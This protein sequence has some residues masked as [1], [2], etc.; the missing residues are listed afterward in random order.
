MFLTIENKHKFQIAA[1]I[2]S[3]GN[4]SEDWVQVDPAEVEK[5]VLNEGQYQLQLGLNIE[6]LSI[7]TVYNVMPG[8]KYYI[9]TDAF[10]KYEDSNDMVEPS[11]FGWVSKFST[12]DNS[13]TANF[14]S[15]IASNKV[16]VTNESHK[17]LYARLS[18]EDENF[19]DIAPGAKH[20]W[21]RQ[22]NGSYHFE[23][24]LRPKADR[25]PNFIILSGESYIIDN[26]LN[27]LRTNGTF[28]TPASGYFRSQ[29]EE[30]ESIKEI[31]SHA[32]DRE[33]KPHIV[34]GG[35]SSS[36]SLSIS[37]VK[38]PIVNYFGREIRLRIKNNGGSGSE[39]FYP[40]PAYTVETW[41]RTKGKYLMEIMVDNTRLKFYV[42][43]NTCY[44]FNSNLSLTDYLEDENVP[45]T[46]DPFDNHSPTPHPQ[47]NPSP[48]SNI[49]QRPNK[50]GIRNSTSD[51][52]YIRIK[53]KGQGSEDLFPLSSNS[54]DFWNRGPG[55]YFIELVKNKSTKYKCY[56]E[57]K[58]NYNLTSDFVLE[59]EDTG[60]T[61]PASN[62]NPFPPSWIDLQDDEGHSED[63][64]NDNNGGGIQPSDNSNYPYFEGRKPQVGSGKFTDND[65]YPSNAILNKKNP[66]PHFHHCKNEYID[67]SGVVWKRASEVLG[68]VQLFKDRIEYNDVKQGQIG[69]CYLISTIASLCRI[70]NMIQSLFRTKAADS[71]GFYEIY[72]FEDGNKKIMFVDDYFPFNTYYNKFYFAQ[73]NGAEIWVL[74]LEK[75]FAKYEGGYCN[76]VGGVTSETLE[77][78]TGCVAN[79]YTDLRSPNLWNN[80]LS[81]ISRGD[82]ICCGT[83]SDGVSDQNSSARGIHYG[84]AY[85]IIDA[86][87]YRGQG[88]N[89]KLLQVRNP[90]GRGEWKGDYS[91]KSYL[92][93]P[94]LKNYFNFDQS[95]SE[96]GIFWITMQD[97]AEEFSEVTIC[98]CGA[99]QGRN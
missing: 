93:T 56:V 11:G 17:M 30:E 51:T 28:I 15:L 81:G 76:I 63:N 88:K 66:N 96:D 43:T 8:Y 95:S 3:D 14:I 89:L 87:E 42:K 24:A 67:P 19:V 45:R 32:E 98:K 6:D 78:L 49:S 61:V 21:V 2:N 44:L 99:K 1:R 26:K 52:V 31:E 35:S 33:G 72:Y 79:D 46:N 84:H 69:D 62:E 20:S 80:I 22:E 34:K 41:T 38:I 60:A 48:Q 5:W 83:P 64:N 65:F 54:Q 59:N 77:Y 70:P 7:P 18:G 50:I 27:L 4:S 91:D 94:E 82:I 12:G 39:D 90:W 29:L 36:V 25:G 92:W 57:C 75:M 86:K 71:R 68:T 53:S 47:P 23:F 55:S 73:P 13:L 74:L 16:Q 85:S 40:I 97:F 58:Y 9:D 10:L 37:D